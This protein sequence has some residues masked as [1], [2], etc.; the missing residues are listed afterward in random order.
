[1]ASLHGLSEPSVATDDVSISFISTTGESVMTGRVCPMPTC[2]AVSLRRTEIF[3]VSTDLREF[4]IVLLGYRM[5]LSVELKCHQYNNF[6]NKED[7]SESEITIPELAH[8]W[9]NYHE[10]RFNF[11]NLILVVF[12]FIL[13]V[14]LHH[15]IV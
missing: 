9:L 5:N 2:E 15:K 10:V 13:D 12:V 11:Q 4:H 3:I 6:K 8:P 14:N 7:Q 1:M